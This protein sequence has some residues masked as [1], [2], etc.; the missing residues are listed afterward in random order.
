MAVR[1]SEMPSSARSDNGREWSFNQI[2]RATTY[3]LLSKVTKRSFH[4][5]E[6]AWDLLTMENSCTDLAQVQ[7][8]AIKEIASHLE[9]GTMV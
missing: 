9:A 7:K 6:S 5:C 1:N 2:N 3:P 8:Y 4:L